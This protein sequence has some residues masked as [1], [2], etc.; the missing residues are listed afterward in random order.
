MVDI[1]QIFYPLPYNSVFSSFLS[2]SPSHRHLSLLLQLLYFLLSYQ[3]F[4]GQPPSSWMFPPG[5]H[6]S[7][8]PSWL[9]KIVTEKLKSTGGVAWWEEYE[10]LLRRPYMYICMDR[11]SLVPGPVYASPR[12]EGLVF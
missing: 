9:V 3:P 5:H 7:A 6:T 1:L 11:T 12:G 4:P 2:S 10:V 8:P